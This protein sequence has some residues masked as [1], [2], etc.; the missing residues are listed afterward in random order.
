MFFFGV[1]ADDPEYSIFKEVI[2]KKAAKQARKEGKREPE[3]D[4]MKHQIVKLT[5]VK[6]MPAPLVYVAV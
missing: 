1:D 3:R 6:L 4:G 5:T 2:A